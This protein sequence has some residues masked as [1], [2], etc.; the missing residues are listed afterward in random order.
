[1]MSA[2]FPPSMPRRISALCATKQ[3]QVSHGVS[4]NKLRDYIVIISLK[5]VISYFWLEVCYWMSFNIKKCRG[6]EKVAKT[7]SQ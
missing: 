3:A 1:M 5:R 6:S 2:Y 7:L 4:I